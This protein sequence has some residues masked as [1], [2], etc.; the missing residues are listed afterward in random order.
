MRA[1]RPPGRGDFWTLKLLMPPLP[2]TCP[3]TVSAPERGSRS[4]EGVFGKKISGAGE[5]F[6]RIAGLISAWGTQRQSSSGCSS[7]SRASGCGGTHRARGRPV[8]RDAGISGSK[9]QDQRPGFDAMH[10]DAARRRFNVVMARSVG[11]STRSFVARSLR[12][13][14]RAAQPWHRPVSCIRR[15]SHNAGRKC[16]APSTSRF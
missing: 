14:V 4:V 3:K 12:L 7:R 11:R 5:D 16:S 13:P 15:A 9:G 8:Y 10:K 6:D 1:E 2:K